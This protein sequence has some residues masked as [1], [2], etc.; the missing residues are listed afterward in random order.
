M[1]GC[2][3]H[4]LSQM[5]ID[6]VAV[7]AGQSP[8]VDLGVG[9]V[10]D[11]VGLGPGMQHVRGDREMGRGVDVPGQCRVDDRD[12]V[13][14]GVELIDVGEP[15]DRLLVEPE[16]PHERNPLL[17]DV[18][19]D[20]RLDHPG[21]G[22]RPSSPAHCRFRREATRDRASRS[23]PESTSRRPSRRWTPAPPCGRRPTSA[24]IG[25]LGEQVV[26]SDQV[27]MVV[28]QRHRAHSGRRSPRR[29]AHKTG[30]HLAV[31]SRPSGRGGRRPSS[32]QSR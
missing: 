31:S 20:R 5:G 4:R 9:P 21:Q 11:D 15:S 7:H 1:A 6:E 24:G 17:G 32:Q 28:H 27:P 10:G 18:R 14:L 26:G 16:V 2:G 25:D 30:D 23:S 8:D 12:P 19:R 13:D 3:A 29:P 22:G